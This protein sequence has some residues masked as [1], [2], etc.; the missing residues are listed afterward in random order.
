MSA[1]LG[2]GAEAQQHAVLSVWLSS[3]V[4]PPSPRNPPSYHHDED[5][6]VSYPVLRVLVTLFHD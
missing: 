1:L 3:A 4:F 6:L 5:T 2:G